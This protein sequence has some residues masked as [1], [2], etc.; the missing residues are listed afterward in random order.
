MSHRLFVATKRAD[1]DV[2]SEREFKKCLDELRYFPPVES[3]WQCVAPS[4]VNALE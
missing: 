3:P 2:V 4:E 1:A